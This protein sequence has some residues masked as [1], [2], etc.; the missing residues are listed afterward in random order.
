MAG[1][2][3]CHT[4]ISDGSLGLEDLIQLARRKGLQT[5][6]ITDHD[7]FAGVTRA[8][9]LGNRYGVNVISGIEFSTYD[10]THKKKVHLLCYLCDKPDRLEG[11]CN[12]T[13]ENRKQASLQMIKK[14]NRYFPLPPDMVVKC[15]NGSTNIY[16]QHIMHA[17]IDAGYTS[18]IYGDTFHQLFSRE[19]GVARVDV[20]YPDVFEVLTTIKDSGGIAVLAHCGVYDNFDLIDSLVDAGLDG[21]EVWHPRHTPQTIERLEDIAREKQLLM[22]GGSDFHGMYSSKPTPLGSCTTPDEELGALLSYKKR[23]K[24]VK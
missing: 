3:H 7:T 2:L 1:D 24:A 12:R 16:K 8:E 21:I 22:T 4:K 10:Y 19:K 13:A 23:L 18:Q 14:V 9:I 15:A 20:S 17:L 5:I 6:A 11:I